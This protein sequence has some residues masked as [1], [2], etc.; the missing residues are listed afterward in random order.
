M[1]NFIIF[2]LV[3]GYVYGVW[4]FSTNFNRTNFER[5][6]GTKIALSILWPVLYIVNGSYRQN[7]N[8]TLSGRD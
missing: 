7:F 3:G 5:N 6:L 4:R 2:G 8:R 1:T